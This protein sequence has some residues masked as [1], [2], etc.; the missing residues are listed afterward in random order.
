MGY[1]LL[2]RSLAALAA[3]GCRSATLTVTSANTSAIRL[4]ERMGFTGQREFAA[5]VWELR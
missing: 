2:R 5:Y 3:N 1:E 4:Y